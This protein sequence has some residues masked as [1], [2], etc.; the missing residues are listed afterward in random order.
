VSVE[1]QEEV[2]VYAGCYFVTCVNC[3]LNNI[4]IPSVKV[5]SALCT[6]EKSHI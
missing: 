4:F 3:S 5:L 2:K 1:D 6:R